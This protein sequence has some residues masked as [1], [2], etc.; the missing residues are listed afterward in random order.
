M[1]GYG[2]LK[3]GLR[4]HDRFSHVI[5]LSAGVERV[6][7]LPPALNGLQGPEDLRARRGEMDSG[8]YRRGLF[9][10]LNYGS[11]ENYRNSKTENPFNLVPDL[12]EGG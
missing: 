10:L 3:I 8:E 5:A 6:G 9:F 12:V 2:A 7:K 11:V 1:G 4:L